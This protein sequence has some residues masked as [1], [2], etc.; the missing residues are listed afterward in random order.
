MN[1]YKF[2]ELNLG[3]KKVFKK[4]IYEKDLELFSE[5]TGDKNPLHLDEEYAKSTLFKR[6]VV[7][8]QLVQSYLSTL[9][10]MYLPGKY[11]LILS[12]ESNFRK[13]VF[14]EDTLLVSGVLEEK[15][16]V[17]KIIIIGTEIKN[18]YNQ[19]VMDGK[20]RVKVLK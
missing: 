18:Q 1:S 8:G 14:I 9:V 11:S 13:P 12:I 5:L 7:F 16:H 2:E 20:M 4:E 3:M 17:G 6:K 10:G 15:I 19:I